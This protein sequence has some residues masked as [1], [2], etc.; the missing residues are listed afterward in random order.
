MGDEL[1]K[2]DNKLTRISEGQQPIINNH[3]DNRNLNILCL[4]SNDNLLDLLSA[5]DG[6]PLA[7]TYVKGCALSRLAGD[8]RI[9]ERV[10][11]LDTLQAA[12]QMIHKSKTKYV[13]YDERQRR[14]V[15][16]NA[17]VLAKKLAAIL[18]RSYLKGMESFQTDI[19]GNHRENYQLC[20]GSDQNSMP[21]LAPYDIQL[22]NAHV[23]ELAD[24]KYQKK[25]LSSLKIPMEPARE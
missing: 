5:S 7:L 25:I 3:N 23:H 2:M 10:Y 8:C 9:L 17:K 6:L 24:E 21:E 14:T 20:E 12:I 11:K 22:W 1:E 4:G 18:Q 19:L 16:S 13:Y 15:E